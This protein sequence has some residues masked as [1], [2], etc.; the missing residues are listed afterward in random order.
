MIV[1]ILLE[2]SS[3]S[4]LQDDVTLVH[5]FIAR[6][7]PKYPQSLEIAPTGLAEDSDDTSCLKCQVKVTREV[8]GIACKL[9]SA[10]RNMIVYGIRVCLL[11]YKQRL[12]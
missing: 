2:M 7:V 9:P 4:L 8:D 6:N 11:R 1:Q 12:V 5:I 10:T 3:S